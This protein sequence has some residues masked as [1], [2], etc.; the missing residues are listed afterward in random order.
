MIV[1]DSSAIVAILKGEADAGA[2]TATLAG[3]DG[4][5][6]S[7]ASYVETGI[8]FDNRDQTGEP[9]R[10][11]HLLGRLGIVIVPV[12]EDLAFAARLAHRRFGRRQNRTSGLN[13][14]DC[15]AYA[16]AKA[17][18]APLLFKGNDFPATDVRIAHWAPAP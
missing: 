5:I 8:V 3:A 15:F 2:L 7:A 11:D 12:T 9:D 10:L 1:I 4:A 6:M 13:F 17:H 16:L 18:D 14:G